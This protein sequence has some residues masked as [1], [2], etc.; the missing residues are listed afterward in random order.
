MLIP[1]KAPEDQLKI[2]S[3]S[4]THLFHMLTTALGMG[5]FH[6]GGGPKHIAVVNTA[7]EHG[8]FESLT[9]TC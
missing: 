3:T 4:G 1:P 8:K 9:R 7:P 5:V 6:P 2:T